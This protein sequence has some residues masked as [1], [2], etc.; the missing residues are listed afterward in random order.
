MRYLITF[1]I[2]VLASA[3]IVALLVMVQEGVPTSSS[4]WA[5]DLYQLKDAH[6]R[7]SGEPKLLIVSG[8]NSV[9]GINANTIKDTYSLPTTNYGVHAGLG[10][11]YL[12][13]R[14]K[15]VLNEGDI[16]YLPL[17]YALYQQTPKPSSQ[18]MD[19]L[20]ATDPEYFQSLPPYEKLHGYLNISFSR[21]WEGIKGGSNRYQ[22]SSAKIYHVM[23]IDKSGNQRAE[24]IEQAGIHTD[25]LANLPPKDIGNGE[26]TAYSREI[27]TGYFEWAQSKN[28]CVIGAPPNLLY[29]EAYKSDNF[30]QFFRGIVSFFNSNDIPFAGSA[31][32]YLLPV[33]LFFDTEYHLNANGIESRTQLTVRD[34]GPDPKRLCKDK[35]ASLNSNPI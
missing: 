20:L 31:K 33:D 17:E 1:F 2:G 15:R 29:H 26:L 10:L 28:I 6:A 23:N 8:S 18:L 13:E 21:I 14:S 22:G 32:D 16:V 12:L 19:F 25:K 24:S 4:K 35:I 30:Q 5:S 34:L 11:R 7:A 27:L 3:G 9:F